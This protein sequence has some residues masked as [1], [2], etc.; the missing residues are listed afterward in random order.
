MEKFR[1]ILRAVSEKTALPTNQMSKQI[2]LKYRLLYHLV[3]P[4]AP[5]FLRAKEIRLS[6]N[7]ISNITLQTFAILKE[8]NL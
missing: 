3:S 8:I 4:C 5:V 6:R 7:A 2:A 1:K